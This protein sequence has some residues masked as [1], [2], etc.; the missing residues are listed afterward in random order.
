MKLKAIIALAFGIVVV[1][2]IASTGAFGEIISGFG[3][4]MGF[5]GIIIGILIVIA[6]IATLLGL[7]GR[8]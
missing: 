8:R 4:A 7:G 6:I 3:S 1:L 5:Y 2:L